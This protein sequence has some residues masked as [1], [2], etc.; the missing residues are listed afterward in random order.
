MWATVC[1]LMCGGEE[2]MIGQCESYR[3]VCRLRLL[4]SVDM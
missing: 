4:S 2:R 3:T 1:A